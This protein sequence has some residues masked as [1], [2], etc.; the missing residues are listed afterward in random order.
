MPDRDGDH[1]Y[2]I[3]SPLE[4]YERAVKE[5]ALIKS[6]SQ[7]VDMVFAENRQAAKRRITLPRLV[8]AL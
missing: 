8:P 6:D 5:S 3:K 7:L 1:M 4:D 2:R